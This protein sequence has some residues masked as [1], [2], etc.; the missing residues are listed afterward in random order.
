MTY[1]DFPL[2]MASL[3]FRQLNERK[4]KELNV[5]KGNSTSGKET[6]FEVGDETPLFAI[7]VDEIHH[8]IHPL[9]LRVK[10]APG[11]EFRV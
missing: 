11:V 4:G 3:G 7:E 5:R 1:H 2:K 6:R 10:P 8:A 9:Q